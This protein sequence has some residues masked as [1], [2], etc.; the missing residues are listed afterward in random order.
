LAHWF[1]AH[2]LALFTSVVVVAEVA[3]PV[4]KLLNPVSTQAGVLH[5]LP[6]VPR[7]AGKPVMA[8]VVQ[9][10]VAKSYLRKLPAASVPAPT[11]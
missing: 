11:T 8:S 2:V 1:T 5:I 6:S 3:V 4:A 9:V 10:L 7:V